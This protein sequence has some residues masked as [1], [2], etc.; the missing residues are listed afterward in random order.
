MV[1]PHDHQGKNLVAEAI[2]TKNDWDDPV[3]E[4]IYDEWLKW[5]SELNLLPTKLV[6][7]CYF[8]KS[9]QVTFLQ[10]HGFSDASENAYAAVVYL[11][12]TDT[13]GKTQIS[14]VSSKI[15][16][17]P[18]KKLTI[19]RLELCRAYLLTQLLF[20]TQNVFNIPLSSVC[21]W[22]DRTIVLNWL[23][24]NPRRFNMYVGNHV[25]SSSLLLSFDSGGGMG[26]WL[27]Q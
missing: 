15:K 21:A 24:G 5:R 6:P 17:A 12:I 14:L 20:H 2:G 19:P 23:V 3:P 8:N 27:G 1:H 22:I 11:R 26:S 16:V 18:I 13:F 25:S 4:A 10:L 9:M 7:Q